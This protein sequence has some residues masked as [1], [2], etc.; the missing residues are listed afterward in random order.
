MA[1]RVEIE[2]VILAFVYAG[3]GAA[4]I[5][6]ILLR[7]QAIAAWRR[8]AGGVFDRSAHR[9]ANELEIDR[10]PRLP[11]EARRKLFESRRV[12]AIGFGALLLALVLNFVVLRTA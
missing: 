10:A 4:M 12:L 5:R 6:A 1:G 11:A 7:R 2:L 3:A 9:F 8:A